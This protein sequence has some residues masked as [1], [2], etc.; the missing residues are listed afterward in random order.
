VGPVFEGGSSLAPGEGQPGPQVPAAEDSG[1]RAVTVRRRR[2]E[3]GR[4]PSS[5][6]VDFRWRA[7]NSQAGQVT[8]VRKEEVERG[9]AGLHSEDVNRGAG[10]AVG[11]PPLDLVPKCCELS[12]HMDGGFE[13]VRTVAEDWEKKG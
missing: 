9:Q 12:C 11:G 4:Q 5:G 8:F 2:V 6:G 13:R 10:K 7:H 3:G 1:V